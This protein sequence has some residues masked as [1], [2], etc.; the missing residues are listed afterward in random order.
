M[1]DNPIRTALRTIA[2][3]DM[4]S[5]TLA[6]AIEYEALDHQVDLGPLR[7]AMELS[8]CAHLEDTRAGRNGIALDPY[9]SHPFRNVLRLLRYG[10]SDGDVLCAAALHDTVED[11]PDRICAFLSVPV[12]GAEESTVR[13]AALD[14]LSSAFGAEVARLVAAVTNPIGDPTQSAENKRLAYVA[15]V[16]DAVADPQVYLVKLAD[17]VDNAGSLDAL[18]DA[19]KRDRLIAKYS[20]LVSVFESG[21]RTHGSELCLRGSGTAAIEDQLRRISARLNVS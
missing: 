19:S 9:I 11:R 6:F 18:S 7:R 16:A 5:A 15:R 13:G 1:T 2:A 12:S 4:D 8:A 21:L 20:P 14:A 17:F 3:K 10:C